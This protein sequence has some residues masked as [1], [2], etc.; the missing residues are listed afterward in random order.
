MPFVVCPRLVTLCLHGFYDSRIDADTILEYFPALRSLYVNNTKFSLSTNLHTYTPH[1]LQKLKI[2]YSVIDNDALHYLS[3]RCNQ[4][5]HVK[6]IYSDPIVE[7]DRDYDEPGQVIVDMSMSNLDTFIFAFTDGLLQKL[8]VFPRH[9]IIEQMDNDNNGL[10]TTQQS[11]RINWY[12][13]YSDRTNRKEKILEWE[14]GRRDIEF[15]QR[16][17]ADFARRQKRG[18]EQEDIKKGDKCDIIKNKLKMGA[19][20]STLYA[21]N[22]H[23]GIHVFGVKRRRCGISGIIEVKWVMD[24]WSDS[25]ELLQAM[26]CREGAKVS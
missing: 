18:K 10:Q 21:S 8:E 9:Y 26:T 7:N 25:E 20:Y 13:V 1:P 6:F 23:M 19:L 14:L 16:Y 12:H 5:K 15:C 22:N 4:L 3:I 2:E 24:Y 17:L 11:P